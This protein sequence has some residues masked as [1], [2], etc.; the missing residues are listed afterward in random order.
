MRTIRATL[1]AGLMV[2]S[3][4]AMVGCG[5]TPAPQTPAVTVADRTP[6]APVRV[7]GTMS[8]V[9][10]SLAVHGHFFY[11]ERPGSFFH[12]KKPLPT[13]QHRIS[14]RPRHQ[15]INQS[16]LWMKFNLERDGATIRSIELKGNPLEKYFL[17]EVDNVSRELDSEFSDEEFDT[18]ASLRDLIRWAASPEIANYD[19]SLIKIGRTSRVGS[20]IVEREPGGTDEWRTVIIRRVAGTQ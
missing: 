14:I 8:S 17:F 12:E 9:E 19:A 1:E 10:E 20:W 5:R 15:S 7:R 11:E 3:V 16:L 6:A 18:T 2:I 13:A 4:V